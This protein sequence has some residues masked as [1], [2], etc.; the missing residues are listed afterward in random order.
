MLTVVCAMYSMTES[1]IGTAMF[2]ATIEVR[3]GSPTSCL[4]FIIYV[5]DLIKLI[6]DNCNDDGFLKWLHILILMDDTVLLSTTRE[7]MI[8]KLSLMNK[9]CDD[10]GMEVNE[11]KTKFFVINGTIEDKETVR[12]GDLKVE[13]C[14]QYM[15]LGSPFTADGS[16]S[17]SVKAHATAKMAHVTKFI[18]FL[19]KNND[20]PFHVKKRVFEACVMSAILYGCESWLNA[21]LRPVMKLYNWA[22]KYLLRVRLSTCNDVC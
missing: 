7:R 18:S 16:V 9:F 4:L 3:Q 20:I 14:S 2:V 12:I 21:D 10:Y 5:N 17:S 1:I 22:L 19:K 11:G 6:K 15:Y 13:P 8:Q